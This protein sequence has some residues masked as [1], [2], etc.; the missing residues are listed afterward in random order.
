LFA[1]IVGSS[2]GWRRRLALPPPKPRSG[3]KPAGQDPSKAKGPQ[4]CRNSDALFAAEIQSFLDNLII[5]AG[6]SRNESPLMPESDQAALNVG[7]PKCGAAMT[8]IGVLPQVGRLRIQES[9]IS[10]R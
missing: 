1:D 10:P 3:D 9:A 8:N 6:S 2:F 7:C 4:R 5:I